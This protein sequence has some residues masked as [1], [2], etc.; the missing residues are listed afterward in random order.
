M[1]EQ[2]VKWGTVTLFA[3]I[4]LWMFNRNILDIFPV[5]ILWI[6]G[7]LLIVIAVYVAIMK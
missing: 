6:I 7:G 2:L 3:A 4:G 5:F 1:A